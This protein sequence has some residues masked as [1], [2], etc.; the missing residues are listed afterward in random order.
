MVIL[1]T[2]QSESTTVSV[3]EFRGL[4][5]TEVNTIAAKSGV[6]VEFSGNISTGG[7]KAYNQSVNAGTAVEA[8][9][10]ITVYFRDETTVD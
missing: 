1:Y 7:L 6:N 9:S 3:P 5:A 2:D 4:T 10:I 8:G